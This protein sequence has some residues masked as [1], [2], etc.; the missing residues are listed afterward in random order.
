[1]C[2]IRLWGRT[3]YKICNIFVP[4]KYTETVYKSKSVKR[5][6]DMYD[7]LLVEGDL[8]RVK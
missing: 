1:M 2:K 3:K 8:M 5:N 7:L 4:V 6:D